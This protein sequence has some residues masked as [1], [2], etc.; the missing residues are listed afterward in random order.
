[1]EYPEGASGDAQVILELVVGAGGEVRDARIVEGAEPFSAAA[2]TVARQWRFEPARRGTAAV[3]A[4]IRFQL[5]FREPERVPEPQPAAAP[6]P[7]AQTLT[8]AEV[9]QLQGAFGE[10]ARSRSRAM[11][12][13]VS[14]SCDCLTWARSRRRRSP[15]GEGTCCWAGVTRTRPI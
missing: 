9:R 4:R 7:L 2:L 6:E 8:C 1:M 5:R 15:M 14:G 10:R 12:C 3:A 13:G 11:S